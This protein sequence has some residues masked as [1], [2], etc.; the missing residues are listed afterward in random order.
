MVP[1]IPVFV[2]RFTVNEPEIEIGEAH[3]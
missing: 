2:V 1:L 3:G